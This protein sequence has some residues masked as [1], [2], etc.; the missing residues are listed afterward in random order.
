MGRGGGAAT[1]RSRWPGSSRRVELDPH[2][3]AGRRVG[4]VG[5]DHRVAAALK[6][7]TWPAAVNAPWPMNWNAGSPGPYSLA[8]M[9][10][11]SIRSP[12]LGLKSRMWSG[13]AA[14]LSYL[15][16]RRRTGRRRPARPARRRPSRSAR[17]PR[18]RRR[19]GRPS[20]SPIGSRCR[21]GGRCRPPWA[22]P[23]ARS[24]TT[25]AGGRRSWRCRCRRRPRA[26]R[27][28]CATVDP[29][30]AVAAVEPV[31][32]GPAVEQVVAASAG[33]GRRPRAVEQVVAAPA[34]QDVGPGVASGRREGR[35]D[36]AL[37]L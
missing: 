4:G 21:P 29:V 10:E 24:A 26:G 34:A 12:C 22:V 23:L 2:L 30:V 19:A 13:A 17:W 33:D 25:P 14:R 8:S 16:R 31:V 1:G 32:A 28:R 9:P 7:R 27:R 35:A 11:R 37:D 36:H 3:R 18:R 15:C 6:K 5:L 20:P